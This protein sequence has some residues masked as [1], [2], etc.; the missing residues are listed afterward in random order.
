[1]KL[2]SLNQK[3]VVFG[4]KGMVGSAILRSLRAKGYNKIFAPTKKEVNL[5][6]F[7]EV[8]SWFTYNNPEIVILAA[9]KVG[10]IFANNEY[11]AD[12]ILENLKIQNNV[13]EN[14][15][16]NKVQKLLFLGSSC[17]Y[18]KYANQPIKEES[19]LKG[20][21]EPTNQ[22]Y[23]IAKIAGIKLCE[24]LNKQ[25]GFDAISLMPTNLYG[26]GDNYHPKNSHVLASLIR[27][28]HDAKLNN[29]EYVTCWGT[30]L[31]LREFLHVNDLAEAC[32]F[33]LEK[34]DINSKDSPKDNNGI[35]L[36]FLNVG[37]GKDISIEE[38]AKLIANII[39]YEGK[40]L[41]DKT[42]KDGTPK[43]QLDVTRLNK[44]G[45]YPKVDFINGLKETIKNYEIENSN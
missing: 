9:A 12:F 18:P 6:N 16:Y 13:I 22:W 31:P 30:G 10:G 25:Y 7:D 26:P 42:K 20:D 29:F 32:I 35:S 36:P 2:I 44:M 23:A 14:S 8:K 15:F 19:L 4:S 24:S 28:F 45:W 3:I 38:L 17:I 1:M 27:R 5:L 43:K 41:W 39:G 37:T 11:P 40:I 33:A 21:L 34:W